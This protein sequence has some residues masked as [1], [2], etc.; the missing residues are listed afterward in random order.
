MLEMEDH[1]NHDLPLAIVSAVTTPVRTHGGPA[2]PA[3][4]AGAT[5]S[6]RVLQL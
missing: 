6:S 4:S 1:E 3:G 5:L 2:G